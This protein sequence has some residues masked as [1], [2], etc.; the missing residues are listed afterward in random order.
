MQEGRR[1]EPEGK[2]LNRPNDL[3]VKS[4][5]SIYQFFRSRIGALIFSLVSIWRLKPLLGKAS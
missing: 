1:Q 5:G 2:Q 3:V 4:D